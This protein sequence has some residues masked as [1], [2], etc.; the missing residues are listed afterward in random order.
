MG[1]QQPASWLDEPPHQRGRHRVGRAG[2][3][4]ERPAGETEVGSVGL[5]HD[6][7]VAEPTAEMLSAQRMSLD[8]DHPGPGCGQRCRQRAPAGADVDDAVAGANAGVSNEPLGPFPFEL[9][10]S[11]LPGRC[12]GHGGGPS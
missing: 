6:D 10:P 5:H 9:V 4:V 7:G 3:D 2:H 8:G 1:G 11:P 12:A